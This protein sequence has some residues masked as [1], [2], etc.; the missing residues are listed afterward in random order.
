[1]TREKVSI[2]LSER[3]LERV[4]RQIEQGEWSSR[5]DLIREA[6]RRVVTEQECRERLEDDDGGISA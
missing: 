2:R 6:T 4:D 3:M 5:S 1:M